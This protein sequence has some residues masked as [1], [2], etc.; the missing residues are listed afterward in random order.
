MARGFGSTVGSGTTDR[1][2]TALTTH[3]AQRSYF[4]RTNRNAG[5]PSLLGRIFDQGPGV[6]VLYNADAS[7]FYEFL[8]TFSGSSAAWHVSRPSTGVW[9][10]IGVRY[11]NG[12][13]ANDPV[14]FTDTTKNTVGAGIVETVA[15]SGTANTTSNAL[16]IGNRTD[17]SRNWDGLLADFAVWDALLDDDEFIALA[18]GFSPRLIR[19]ASLV[20]FVPMVRDNLSLKLA[21]PTVTGTAVQ[22]HA[23][24]IGGR[25]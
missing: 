17:G 6:I 7:N 4:V 11:D 16:V 10:T 12:S 13:T 19:P 9:Q 18:R 5:G 1:I 20:E 25:R 21:A 22:P 8:H 24:V 2:S 3:V 23:R 15:P 14:I